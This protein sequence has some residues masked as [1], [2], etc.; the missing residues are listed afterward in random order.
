MPAIITPLSQGA[1]C[2]KYT[3]EDLGANAPLRGLGVSKYGNV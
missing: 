1:N 3:T 2:T